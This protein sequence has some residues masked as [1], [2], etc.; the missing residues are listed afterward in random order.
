MEQKGEIP[1]GGG[2]R[3]KT[4]V[5]KLRIAVKIDIILFKNVKTN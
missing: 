1:H 5:K 3:D 4:E 2:G